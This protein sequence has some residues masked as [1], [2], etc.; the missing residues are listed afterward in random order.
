MT[1]AGDTV[2]TAA[3]V[4]AGEHIRRPGE[5]MRAGAEVLSAGTRL[6]GIALGA[7]VAAGWGEV[8]VSPRPHVAVLCTGDELRRRA[9]RSARVRSTIP[10]R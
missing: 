5:D 8:T 7:A 2:T 9:N 6:D 1:V 3:D 4:A 10:T